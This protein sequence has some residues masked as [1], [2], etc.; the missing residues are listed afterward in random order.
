VTSALGYVRLHGRNY[1]EWFEAETCADRYN[2]LYK[3]SELA[4]WK[5]RVENIAQQAKITFVV[6]NNHFEA[7]AGVNALQLKYMLTG[8]RVTAPESLLEHYPQLRT[9]SDP[10]REEQQGTSLPLLA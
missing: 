3:P 9:I 1:E 10:L 6:T 5:E 8:R 7:K 2:Y 4:G